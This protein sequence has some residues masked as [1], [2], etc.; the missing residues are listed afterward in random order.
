MCLTIIYNFAFA[1]FLLL[2]YVLIKVFEPNEREKPRTVESDVPGLQF[3]E[4]VTEA[5]LLFP[6]G[7]EQIADAPSLQL[8]NPAVGVVKASPNERVQPRIVEQRP[9]I[10]EA[11][12]WLAR[13]PPAEQPALPG[14]SCVSFERDGQTRLR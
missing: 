5:I 9:E 6:S 12:A 10:A 13:Q 2:G 14:A 1:L 11:L 4:E 8:R 7:F 3:Q